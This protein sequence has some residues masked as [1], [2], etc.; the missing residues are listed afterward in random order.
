MIN[1]KS[2]LSAFAT[3]ALVSTT[4]AFGRQLSL[5]EAILNAPADMMLPPTRSQA[6]IAYTERNNDLNV[7]YII[8]RQNDKGYVVLSAD[9]IFPAVLGY[10]D[11]GAFDSGNI[12]PAMKSW[13]RN[14]SSQLKYALT[15][16]YRKANLSDAADMAPISPL[17]TTKWNQGKPYN[18][19]CPVIDGTRAY[20]GCTATAMAQVLFV[21]KTP[22][23]GTGSHTYVTSTTQETLTFDFGATTFNW[24]NM[25]D[26]YSTTKYSPVQGTAVAT[27]ML[28]CGN[29]ALMNYE[30]NASGAYLYDA[31]YGMVKYMGVDKSAAL[32]ERDYYS[33]SEWNSIIYNELKNGRPVLY[34]GSNY[35]VGHSF[36]VDGYAGDGYYHVNWGWSG[37]SDGYFLLTA[38]D[39]AEQGAGGSTDGYNF[40]QDALVNVMAAK[41][42]SKYQLLVYQRGNLAT[43]KVSYTKTDKIEFS[44]ASGG[45][46]HG[47]TLEDTKAT[48]GVKLTPADG[49]ETVFIPGAEIEF[50][51]Y[52]G[53]VNA[54]AIQKFSVD[55]SSFPSS[56]SY[57]VTVAYEFGGEVRDVAVKVGYSPSVTATISDETIKFTTNKVARTLVAEDLKLES[58]PYIGKPTT[59][60][61]VIKNS[62]EEYLGMVYPAL[63]TTGRIYIGY[64]NGININIEDGGS[65]PLTFTGTFYNNN[66]NL[67]A[68]KYYITLCDEEGNTLCSSM[69][70]VE[71]E[72]V[73][74]GNPVF[75]AHYD[76]AGDPIGEGTKANPYLV[77]N[78]FD[79]SL[80]VDVTS[81]LL[82]N[83]VYIYAYDTTSD[84]DIYFGTGSVISN[85]YFV[86][87]GHSLTKEFTLDTS[88]LPLDKTIFIAAYGW[89][90]AGSAD[91]A[92]IGP[93]VYLR[94]TSDGVTE[95]V[96]N[97]QKYTL[98][99]NPAS[100]YTTVTAT[101]AI[102]R[103]EVYSINGAKVASLI[104]ASA[105]TSAEISVESF[106]PGH[107]IVVVT[108]DD[109]VRSLRLIK[110]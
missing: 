75:T 94:R 29:A 57:N 10:A 88:T 42:D 17:C 1:F 18:D 37:M 33:Y 25:L 22:K 76:I 74:A 23:V 15:N 35:E 26:D 52:Y 31:L 93:N 104:P 40:Y 32:L 16:G 14:Y 2:H 92:W 51:T 69:L 60:S 81:G 101:S 97:D 102:R 108:T 78:S 4:A 43:G 107:Y 100:S 36:V 13:L 96:D 8:N 47:F 82:D 67:S 73:P 79:C 63:L 106:A 5:E 95:I 72:A 3:I 50:P 84:D 83:N 11:S 34:D 64:L 12:P 66:S 46:F 105:E 27:L 6:D 70:P 58:A 19:Q 38:L 20:T 48:M 7:A 91:A 65:L 62:G 55:A 77:G 61:A 53:E 41:D 80:T 109:N 39:P 21:N 71:F 9:D 103:I 28:A 44:V 24:D 68:G 110:K 54:P 86:G 30:K 87:E 85:N 56:G 98:L 45:Y 90:N 89:G 49:G 99:P 59:I